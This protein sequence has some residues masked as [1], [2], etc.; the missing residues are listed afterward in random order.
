MRPRASL[1]LAAAL[2]LGGAAGAD[3]VPEKAVLGVVPFL[4][5]PEPNR[6]F[7]DLAPE[8]SKRRLRMLL[9]TGAQHTVA[10]PR[11]AKELGI[12][13]RRQK[14]DPYRRKTLL[15]RDLQ[16][17]V[18]TRSSDTASK[19]G[20]EYALLG[21]NFL[22]E[23]VLELDFEARRVRFL[24]P[25]RYRMPEATD[26]P[27]EAVLPI[28]VD[29]RR[30][31]VKVK[32]NGVESWVLLDTGAPMAL[33]LDGASARAA[34]VDGPVLAEGTG[35]GVLGPTALEVRTVERFELGPFAFEDLPVAVQPRGFYNQG[36]ATD[37][38][39]GYELLADF[40]VRIDY[41]NRRLWLK[42]RPEPTEDA[43]EDASEPA[44]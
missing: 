23:Y 34:G 26:A 27:D 42:R 28:R 38:V 35:H 14:Y 22:E 24:H 20:W 21:G 43:T 44:S 33:L 12:R 36:G 3:D 29:G 4:E 30:P 40:L 37:S 15:G 16:I 19:T 17:L 10:T 32:L 8:K 1:A 39:I 2:L 7:V 41:P 6:I 11:A 25:R 13:V 5:Y 9:D 31:F 18:D